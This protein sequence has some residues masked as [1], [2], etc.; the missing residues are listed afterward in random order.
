MDV[1]E[2]QRKLIDTYRIKNSD[3]LKQK[4][5]LIQ[6]YKNSREKTKSSLSKSS[7]S[8]I[9]SPT[10]DN[11]L[12]TDKRKLDTPLPKGIDYTKLKVERNFK[13]LREYYNTTPKRYNDLNEASKR[14]LKE[15][16][17]LP[18]ENPELNVN[19]NDTLFKNN[20]NYKQIKSNY[21]EMINKII[22][23][24]SEFKYILE[25]FNKLF[26]MY[27]NAYM[28]INNIMNFYI[29]LNKIINN[30]DLENLFE[31]Y[32]NDKSIY[33][34]YYKN[35]FNSTNILLVIMFNYFLKNMK[36][37]PINNIKSN[38]L[39]ILNI[40]YHESMIDEEHYENYIFNRNETFIARSLFIFFEL[41]F[42]PSFYKKMLKYIDISYISISQFRSDVYKFIIN[43][44]LE[45]LNISLSLITP[46]RTSLR[47][48]L[49]SIP[50]S[51]GQKCIKK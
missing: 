13:M 1:K 26:D 20:S 27:D 18:V 21:I 41:V 37:N 19:L 51:G 10:Y 5:F 4:Q 9:N 24:S 38:E 33:L 48:S 43:N 7:S 6:G 42:F 12:V 44:A 50:R 14:Y 30:K 3:L 31:L 11:A 46:S 49:R 25:L 28:N 35:I 39:F 45:S 17:L 34:N 23:G 2:I 22:N 32:K 36:I 47:S 15:T 16:Y 8:K 40:F 29:H